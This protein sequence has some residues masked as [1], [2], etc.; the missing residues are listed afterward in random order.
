[1][2]LSDKTS[3]HALTYLKTKP[4]KEGPVRICQ[5]LHSMFGF[6]DEIEPW[7]EPFGLKINRDVFE[8]F[9]MF[10]PK[11]FVRRSLTL[12]LILSPNAKTEGR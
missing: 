9:P 6:F 11:D 10:E 12:S 1:M 3:E 8:L 7:F 4:V 2:N 5:Y